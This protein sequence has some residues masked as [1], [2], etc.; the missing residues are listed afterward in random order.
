MIRYEDPQCYDI[1]TIRN[2][3]INKDK[4]KLIEGIIGLSLYAD[5]RIELQ[6]FIFSIFNFSDDKD[7]KNAC[8]KAFSHIARIDG[9]IDKKVMNIIDN[10]KDNKF[11]RNNINDLI[12]DIE[13]YSNNSDNI[14][15]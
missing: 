11:Y 13:I 7:I 3:I 9:K 12:D 2:F 1:N 14:Y 10:Y 6:D 5:D 15:D 4:N 8:I